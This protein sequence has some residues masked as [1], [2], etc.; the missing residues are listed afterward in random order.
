MQILYVDESGDLGT[1]PATPAPNCNDQPVLIIG[2]LIVDASRLEAITQ[3][4]LHLKSRWF[5]GLAYPSQNHLDKIIPEIKGA[6]LRRDLTRSGRNQKRHAIGFLDRL[7]TM[8]Q[9]HG[10][11]V[12]ARVWVKGLGQPFNGRSVY[13]SSIQGLYLRYP[14]IFLSTNSIS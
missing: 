13:T 7:L 11:R 10:A 4:F 14:L 6:D 3:D 9:K 2:A 5:P 8:L 12:L 1:L